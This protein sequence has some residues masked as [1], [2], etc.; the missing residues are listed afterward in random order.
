MATTDEILK[1]AGDLG[2]MIAEHP[3][4]KKF[5]D[6]TRKLQDDTEAQRLL[7]DFNRH[8]QTLQEK[9]A[10][11][12]P[13]EVADKHKLEE[14]QA[15]VIKNKLVR[16]LQ[17]AQMDFVDLMRRVDEAMQGQAPQA[18][19]GPVGQPAIGRPS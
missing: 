10:K 16:D 9:E 2:K 15:K 12:Q 5:E 1:A 3:A 13:I 18:D 11:R 17:M 6:V 19:A 14:L 7:T 8:M 4:A